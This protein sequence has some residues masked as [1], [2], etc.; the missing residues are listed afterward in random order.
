MEFCL[1]INLFRKKCAPWQWKVELTDF[2][3]RVQDAY[4][5]VPQAEGTNIG[6][7]Y[8]TYCASYI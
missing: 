5:T 4:Y 6:C 8:R 2:A 3:E 7:S 1:D